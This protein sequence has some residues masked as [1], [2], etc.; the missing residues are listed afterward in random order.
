MSRLS[1]GWAKVC[2]ATAR[3]AVPVTILATG[4]VPA[5]ADASPARPGGPAR[6]D[7]VMNLDT[8]VEVGAPGAIAHVRDGQHE[9]NLAAGES[10]CGRFARRV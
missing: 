9:W 3:V 10:D 1:L 8:I 5:A 6:D 2:R 7:I 4:V